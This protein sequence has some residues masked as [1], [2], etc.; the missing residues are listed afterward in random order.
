[1]LITRRGTKT[2]KPQAALRPMPISTLT[3]VSAFMKVRLARPLFKSYCSVNSLM[4]GQGRCRHRYR[5]RNRS[6]FRIS[7]AIARPIATPDRYPQRIFIRHRVRQRRMRSRFENS[8]G[9]RAPRAAIPC[10]HA[11]PGAPRRV[12]GCS[13]N[14][15]LCRPHRAFIP[16]SPYPGRRRREKRG[17][18]DR[19]QHQPHER[20]DGGHLLGPRR[21]RGRRVGFCPRRGWRRETAPLLGRE[22][23]ALRNSSP[24]ITHRRSPIKAIGRSIC[25]PES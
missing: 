17:V 21:T 12:K 8:L 15:L 11:S 22:N 20:T 10:F 2:L 4:T 23:L 24:L 1:M 3:K 18:P 13:E 19:L 25:P 7:I 6:R 16:G 5:S 9:A 14:R